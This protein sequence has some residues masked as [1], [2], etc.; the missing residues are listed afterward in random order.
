MIAIVGRWRNSGPVRD[1]PSQ[2][3]CIG[4][5]TVYAGP[6]VD[7]DCYIIYNLPIFGFSRLAALLEASQNGA[8]DM[9]DHVNGPVFTMG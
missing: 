6:Y 8:L 4:L 3:W 7:V 2:Q 9:R 1:Q 5:T